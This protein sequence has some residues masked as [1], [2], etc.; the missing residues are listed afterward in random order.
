[1]KFRYIIFI[2]FILFILWPFSSINEDID[3]KNISYDETKEDKAQSIR[4]LFV[5]KTTKELKNLQNVVEEQFIEPS[6]YIKIND[7]KYLNKNYK[8]Y[9]GKNIS[10]TG[11]VGYD[12]NLFAN[13]IYDDEGY[14]VFISLNQKRKLDWEHTYTIKGLYVREKSYT[15]WVN[16]IKEH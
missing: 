6:N 7:F 8:K 11:K 15:T 4:E 14:M 10:V 3:N 9:L 2:L 1:M 16:F 12:S 5:T 13:Y